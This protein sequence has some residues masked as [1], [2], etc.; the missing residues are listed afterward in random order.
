ILVLLNPAPLARPGVSVAINA[1]KSVT[2]NE[3]GPCDR[4]TK[5][6][7][8]VWLVDAARGPSKAT[9]LR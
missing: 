6:A 5:R 2:S 7:L 1:T 3:N 4:A 8:E 9:P